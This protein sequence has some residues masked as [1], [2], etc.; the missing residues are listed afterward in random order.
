MFAL[1][2]GIQKKKPCN[3]VTKKREK[4]EGE[5][6]TLARTLFLLN[7]DTCFIG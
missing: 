7:A 3:D 1:G 5:K 4:S 2:I 6:K